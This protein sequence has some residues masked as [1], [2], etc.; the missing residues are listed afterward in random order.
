MQYKVD[1][2]S[3]SNNIPTMD[4]AG[5]YSIYYRVLESANYYGTDGTDN[6]TNSIAKVTPTVVAPTP[7]VLTY[8]TSSQ[9]LVNAG[10]TNWGT[11][12][13][14]LD[15][16]SWSTNIPEAINYGS[17]T[18][19]YRVVGNSNINSVA[20]TSVAC[21]IA[22]KRVSTPTI[23]LDPTEYTYNGKACE[24]SVVV[25]DGTH[26]IPTSEYTVTY[27]N[28]IN[29]GT[30]TVTITDNTAGN[31]DITGT[32]DFTINKAAG[33]VT[34]KPTAKILTYNGNAQALVNAGSGT[35]T[36]YYR[37]GT[38]GSFTTTV[39][40]ATAAG[41]YTVYFYAAESSNYL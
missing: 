28:N 16:S 21:S 7:R 41:S 19:Y 3:W 36:I 13:Y 18:V 31:Y 23:E 39:P 4:N 33:S 38:S 30:A 5:T 20:S 15:N 40:T 9:A 14:S 25:K 11:L 35:G 6:I 10:S 8:N 1:S 17:Y 22:E 37:V 26:V 27:S 29:A 34:T 2:G 24:P 12:Q 32:K